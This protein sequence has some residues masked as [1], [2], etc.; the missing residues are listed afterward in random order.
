MAL[1][2]LHQRY[3]PRENSFYRKYYHWILVGVSAALFLLS[4]MIIVLLYQ[5]YNKPL[6]VFAAL[7]PQGQSIPLTPYDSP[8]LQPDVI[9][10]FAAQAT[11][12]AYTYNFA[13]YQNQ[14]KAAR[15]YFTDNGWND[16]LN[17][18]NG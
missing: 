8:N 3:I 11:T 5:V 6:P 1:E 10:R 15:P 9:T 2:D 17:A 4:C 13:N 12:I 14:L 18:I 7:Q 16:Y